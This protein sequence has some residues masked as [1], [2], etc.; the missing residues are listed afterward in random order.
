[1]FMHLDFMNTKAVV[2]IRLFLLLFFIAFLKTSYGQQETYFYKI[3]AITTKEHLASR[4]Y[5]RLDSLEKTR[6]PNDSYVRIF[7]NRDVDFGFKHERIDLNFNGTYYQVN[8]LVKN[9]TA[10]LTSAVFSTT[11]EPYYEQFNKT[12]SIPKIDSART[13]NYLKLRN[14]FYDSSKTLN[15][16][17]NELDLDRWYVLRDGDG[18]QETWDKKHI[19]TLV[20]RKDFNELEMML[21]SINCET[22]TYA[23]RGFDLLRKRKVH[24]PVKDKIIVSYIKKRNSDLESTAGDIGP[25]IWKAYK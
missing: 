25:I 20:I 16:L 1:M 19:N 7:F 11:F 2:I 3:Q 17:K 23:V 12:H 21:K 9:D 18:Y 10:C 5:N 4:I 15:D 24:V 22:Q 8:M 13:L 14:K 6:R